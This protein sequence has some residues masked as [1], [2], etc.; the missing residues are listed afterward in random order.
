MPLQRLF[1]AARHR[2][3]TDLTATLQ[4]AECSGLVLHTASGNHPLMAVPMH[5]ASG[6]AYKT[7]VCFHCLPAP[8]KFQERLCLNRKPD[9]L[10][11]EPSRLL[12][13]T[14]CAMNLIGADPVLTVHQQPNGGQPLF[15]WDRGI[16]KDRAHLE[17][18]LLARVIP[19]AAI[20][21]RLRQERDLFRATIRALDSA[22]RPTNLDHES[23]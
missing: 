20:D 8:S 2:E 6:T 3:D 13:Y 18:E 7:L 17:R 23:A 19:I 1:T 5:E 9:A 12:C 15:K 16:L 14:E 22:F 4:D 11:H 21:P 10:Q